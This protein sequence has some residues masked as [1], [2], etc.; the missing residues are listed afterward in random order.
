MFSWCEW[1]I[2]LTPLEQHD[3]I[4]CIVNIIMASAFNVKSIVQ[5]KC[6]NARRHARG[7]SKF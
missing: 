5:G 4:G 2:S 1:R 6:N 7:F 3:K